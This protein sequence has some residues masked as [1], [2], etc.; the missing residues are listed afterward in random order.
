[1][2]VTFVTSDVNEGSTIWATDGNDI[3]TVAVEAGDYVVVMGRMLRDDR[4]FSGT[5]D[6]NSGAS[7]TYTT[8]SGAKVSNASGQA[9]MTWARAQTTQTLNITSAWSGADGGNNGEHIAM[10]V[11]GLATSQ[12]SQ[13]SGTT[14][15]TNSVTGT[16]SHGSGGTVAPNPSGNN[17]LIAFLTHSGTSGWTFD[18]DFAGEVALTA[19]DL[20]AFY[21][22]DETNATESYAATSDVN[23]DS[24]TILLMLEGEAVGDP[25]PSITNVDGDNTVTLSQANITLTGTDIDTAT[26]E[27]RQGAFTYPCN[28]DSQN[29]TTIVFD[30]PSNSLAVAPKHGAATLAVI[31]GDAQEDTQAITITADAG[32]EYTDVGTPNADDEIRLT[33]TADVVS[34]DQTQQRGLLGEDMADN[35]VATD[36]TWESTFQFEFRIWDQSDSSWGAWATQAINPEGG[37]DGSTSRVARVGGMMVF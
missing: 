9:F 30:M 28:I 17:V 23:R 31:N 13:V 32:S 36:L 11:R 20:N 14:Y 10:V 24:A 7:N 37:G 3:V 34:G 19:N 18:A 25:A 4:T 16:T 5:T 35:E 22:L 29:G 8:V 12:P 26:V 15:L 6:D 27:I 33:G 1:M 21:S 2:A